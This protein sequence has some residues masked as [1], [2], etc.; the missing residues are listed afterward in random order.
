MTSKTRYQLLGM[1]LFGVL[2]VGLAWFSQPPADAPAQSTTGTDTEPTGSAPNAATD[3][4]QSSDF[5]GTAETT[6]R[7]RSVPNLARGVEPGA[8]VAPIVFREDHGYEPDE[9][10][11]HRM[12]V[13]Q[14]FQ[15]NVAGWTPTDFD[16]KA[17]NKAALT[18][19]EAYEVYVYLRSC[20]GQPESL[21]DVEQQIDAIERR[22]Q[23]IQPGDSNRL[24]DALLSR[25]DRLDQ[26]LQRCEGV[27]T[28]GTGVALMHDWLSLAADLGFAQAQIAYHM[29]ARWILSMQPND[30]FRHP[31][32]V[33]RY[34]DRA[35]QYL[36]S[37]LRSGHPDAILAMAHAIDDDIVFERDPADVYAW[38]YAAQLAEAGI[39]GESQRYIERA[40]RELD[41]REIREA[42]ERG[43]ALCDRY[44][45]P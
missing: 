24:E 41:D 44:C 7:R 33:M 30:L 43:R 10:S 38:A 11:Q 36:T 23:R 27:G 45:R 14:A 1:G 32:L 35:T 18:G 5:P 25:I 17:A 31:D 2:L 13:F 22:L 16:D 3:T 12:Q 39:D 21:E 34:R 28:D 26:G 20:L 42:R 15:R 37:A 40:T 9:F 8:N 4:E 6:E 29:S 19:R